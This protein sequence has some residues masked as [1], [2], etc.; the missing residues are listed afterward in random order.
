MKMGGA[1]PLL[2]RSQISALYATTAGWTF[3][4]FH[5]QHLH[6]WEST[7]SQKASAAS[8]HVL[9]STD[10]EWEIRKGKVHGLILPT[11]YKATTVVSDGCYLNLFIK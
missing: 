11:G 1:R 6:T 7:K 3:G 10:G 4:I 9:D 5:A 8:I 2:T